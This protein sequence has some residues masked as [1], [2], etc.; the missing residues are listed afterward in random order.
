MH[1]PGLVE[2]RFVYGAMLLIG[3]RRLLR[4]LAFAPVD[5]RA[6][7]A[8]RLLGARE[9]LQTELMRRHRTRRCT[10]AGAGVDAL[11]SASMIALAR[12]D[13]SRRR[14]ARASAATA[15]AWAVAELAAA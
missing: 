11:H 3:P 5:R 14:L 12:A 6:M 2:L 15:A 9:L 10:L 8:A 4:A 1:G 7:G 13:R